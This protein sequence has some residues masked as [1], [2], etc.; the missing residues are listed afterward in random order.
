MQLTKFRLRNFRNHINSQIEFGGGINVLVGDNGQ[1]KTNIIEA[2]SYLCL[3][4]SFYAGGDAVV[5]N[6][7]QDFF[8][9]EGTFVSAS[10]LSNDVRVAY[11]KRLAQKTYFI[12]RKALEPLSSVVGRFPLVICSPEHAPITSGSPSERRRFVDFVVSQSNPVYF[13]ALVEY[14]RSLKQRNKIL[15]DAR[16]TSGN[17]DGLLEPWDDQI[18]TLGG[19]L[20]KRREKFVNEFQTYIAPTYHRIVEG[21]EDPQIQYIPNVDGRSEEGETGYSDMLRKSIVSKRSEERHIGTTL[22]GPHRD[23]IALMINGLDLRKFASQGQHKTFLVALKLAEFQY[24]KERCNETP[25]LLMDDVFSELDQHR[26]D[27]LLKCIEH[28]SQTFITSTSHDVFERT[29]DFG[30]SH[31]KFI[32]HTGSVAEQR[33]IGVS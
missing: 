4:K 3:T 28:I 29:V 18:V 22:V 14:R 7:G 15:L 16:I 17:I 21:G 6:L 33:T 9:I 19:E 23:E 5:L 2:I 20:M 1:G 27:K 10:N 11:D 12:N 25:I 30:A 31:R 32:V 24:L 8:E 26:S 13:N